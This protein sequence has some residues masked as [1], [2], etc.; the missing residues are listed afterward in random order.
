MRSKINATLDEGPAAFASCP[1]RAHTAREI[2][3]RFRGRH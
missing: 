1:R 2:Y 3:P